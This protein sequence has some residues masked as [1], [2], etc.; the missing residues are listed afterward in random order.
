MLAQRCRQ[1]LGQIIVGFCMLCVQEHKYLFSFCGFLSSTNFI[2][3][4]GSSE[5]AQQCPRLGPS[6]L[7]ELSMAINKE[8]DIKSF[9]SSNLPNSLSSYVKGF[10]EI[11]IISTVMFLS[12]DINLSNIDDAETAEYTAD[13]RIGFLLHI[14]V[15]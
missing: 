4:V 6:T 7:F 11:L 10:S 3:R 12:S 2:E 15:F 1:L 14:K 13:V 5:R 9:S 8:Y